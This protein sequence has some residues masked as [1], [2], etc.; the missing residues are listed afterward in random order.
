LLGLVVVLLLPVQEIPEVRRILK[1]Q[2]VS[3][4]V[5]VEQVVALVLVDVVVEH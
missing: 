1:R 4:L 2:L 5:G 3:E